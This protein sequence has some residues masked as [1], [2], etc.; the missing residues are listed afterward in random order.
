MSPSHHWSSGHPTGWK[1]QPLRLTMLHFS[2]E[3][4]IQGTSSVSVTAQDPTRGV[5]FLNSWDNKC[6]HSSTYLPS[7]VPTEYLQ[8]TC[9]GY[10][11]RR[12][13][14]SLSFVR[15]IKKDSE[16]NNY[17]NLTST[18]FWR[19]IVQNSSWHLSCSHSW[20]ISILALTHLI[21]VIAL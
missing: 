18:M 10:M 21:L 19:I 5:Y 11:N 2:L 15:S 6:Q 16:V 8:V 13:P 7:A 1:N 17:N 9:C 14:L 3:V 4:L 12:Y 20:P